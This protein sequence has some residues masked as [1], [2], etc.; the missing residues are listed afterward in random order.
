MDG[1][2]V[3]RVVG[4]PTQWYGLFVLGCPA[5]YPYNRVM[6]TW[7]VEFCRFQFST[8]N[9]PSRK[10]PRQTMETTQPFG[11]AAPLPER[12]GRY[13]ILKQLGKGGMGSVYLAEDTQLQRRVALKV[14]HI[15]A[16]D[17]PAVL[18]R[19]EREARA[20][21]T[22]DHPNICQVYDVGT[23]AGIPYLTMAF[24]EGK[25]LAALLRDGKAL[26]ERQTIIVV[27]KLA[28]ALHEAH[29]KG[30]I[31]RDLK[32]AN[33]MVNHR[34][35]PIL[36]DFGLAHLAHRQSTRLTQL[37]VVMGTLTYMPPEQV[38]GDIEA[39][40]PGCDIWS[41]GVILYELLTGRGPFEGPPAVVMAQILTQPPK[42]PSALCPD[43]DARLEAVCLQALAKDIGSRYASMGDMAQ[44]LAV[45]L[46]TPA[47]SQPRTPAATR[48]AGPNPSWVAEPLHTQVE[49]IA[50][51]CPACRHTLSVRATLQGQQTQCPQCKKPFQVPVLARVAPTQ[52]QR[53]VGSNAA[54]AQPTE[55]GKFVRG[56]KGIAN[57][58]RNTTRQ[59]LLYLGC[60]GL[61]ITLA[62]FAVLVWVYVL[63]PGPPPLPSTTKDG[64]STATKGPVQATNTGK[65]SVKATA[66][67]KGSAKATDTGKPNIKVTAEDPLLAGMKFVKLPKGRFWMGWD[68]DK[69]QSQQVEIKEDFEL[70]VCTVTQE[71]WETVMGDTPSYFSRQGDGKDKVQNISDV[72]LKQFPVESVSWEDVQK[73]LKKLNER[74]KGRGE[75]Y[76]LP[77][78]AEWEYA[79]RGGAT[80]K[81]ACSYD[82]YFAQPTN[83]LSSKQANFNGEFP[84][85][86]AAKGPYLG[87][88]MKVGS[89]APNKWGLYDMHGNVWQWCSDLYDATGS[90][91]VI[92]GGGWNFY[93]QDCRAADR[94]WGAPTSRDNYLGFRLAR[95]LSGL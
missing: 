59:S 43:V 16:E 57:T 56:R 23:E 88:P 68:S 7:L 89:Y 75:L 65:P 47:P 69:K 27:R 62:L 58:Q 95:V 44:A 90:G 42:P 84:A 50:V 19:F 11:G 78:E 60:A 36:M 3:E 82:F 30:V 24:V 74:T 34:G 48:P 54:L 94:N 72:E 12:F 4:C 39:M 92:R 51:P 18:A 64:T 53:A 55:V 66:A 46:R 9:L 8:S 49:T 29:N 20:A 26:T 81:E 70:A 32:P 80:S 76:R 40:G 13:R 5:A 63:P 17:G 14:P 1:P 25:T 86:Q 28:L 35:E 93:G 91:R 2:Q 83:D 41:L 10:Q 38:R 6:T 22:L 73:F 85:G 52:E 15:T 77:S 79:C 45:C 37:G 67:I 61:V 31:H 71:Q 87:R 33:V 21:A